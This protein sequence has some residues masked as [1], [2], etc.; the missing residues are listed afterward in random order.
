MTPSDGTS[1]SST[2]KSPISTG[3][4]VV[5]VNNI[6]PDDSQAFE[7]VLSK[8]FGAQALVKARR[9]YHMSHVRSVGDDTQQ[10]SVGR[11][12]RTRNHHVDQ[13]SDWP[14][15]VTCIFEGSLH[16]QETRPGPVLA[17][18]RS[19][20][21]WDSPTGA[22]SIAIRDPVIEIALEEPVTGVEERNGKIRVSSELDGA[23]TISAWM[24][25]RERDCDAVNGWTLWSLHKA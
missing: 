9:S 12:S 6:Q 11:A 20:I 13:I 4:V 2:N 7:D 3:Y 24:N 16:T 15:T 18:P 1:L 25:V 10:R 17:K 14:G 8:H 23:K 22:E 5:P 19:L 21:L